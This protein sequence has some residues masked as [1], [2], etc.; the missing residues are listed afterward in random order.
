MNETT[1]VLGNEMTSISG[2]VVSSNSV[3]GATTACTYPSFP[4]WTGYV[5]S[6]PPSTAWPMKIRAV[7]NGY[8]LEFDC[9]EYVASDLPMLLNLI[10]QHTV[11]KKK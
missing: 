3:L 9:K 8:I 5:T 1:G 2:S 10:K 4:T 11:K 7:E 6:Y